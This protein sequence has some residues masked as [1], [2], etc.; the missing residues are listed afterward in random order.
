MLPVGQPGAIWRE[1]KFFMTLLLVLHEIY[2]YYLSRTVRGKGHLQNY[3]AG[4]KE[5]LRLSCLRKDSAKTVFSLVIMIT[6]YP[7]MIN[8]DLWKWNTGL[9]LARVQLRSFFWRAT[10]IL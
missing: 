4:R 2:H 9:G 7:S 5:Y 1:K 8:I 6:K 3:I 10:T